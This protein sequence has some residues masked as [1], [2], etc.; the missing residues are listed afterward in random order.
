MR[1]FY[2]LWPE[3]DTQ[4]HWLQASAAALTSLGGQPLPAAS[5][6][7][8]LQFLGETRADRVPA[9]IRLGDDVA[10][11]ALSLRFDRIECWG[12]GDL[13]CLRAESPAELLR[14]VG[15][16]GHGLQT[17]GLAPDPRRFKAHVTLA[18][19]L[20]HAAPSLPLWP[21]LDWQATTLALVSSRL[22][23]EGPSYHAVARWSLQDAPTGAGSG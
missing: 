16:L 5:L 4:R 21:P 2:A 15:H 17:L 20:Q 3:P 23:A 10:G 6:H 19:R 18:R 13:A 9:L 14:L 1:L 7:L 8:T 11:A 12:R 22:A